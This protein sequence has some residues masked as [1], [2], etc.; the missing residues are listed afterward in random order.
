MPN[1]LGPLRLIT[2]VRQFRAYESRH[3]IPRCGVQLLASVHHRASHCGVLYRRFCS[4]RRDL[5]RTAACAV[6]HWPFRVPW[7]E[8]PVAN[9]GGRITMRIVSPE[10]HQRSA[11][12]RTR[13]SHHCCNPR[14]LWAASLS[15]GSLA[16][17]DGPA[18]PERMAALSPGLAR[19]GFRGR[20]YPGEPPTTVSKP[21]RFASSPFCHR[22]S[23]FEPG[24]DAALS[25]LAA[26]AF[27]APRVGPPPLCPGGPTLG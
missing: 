10:N 23:G 3:T 17:G 2:V 9:F 22:V 6:D 1:V 21:E 15:L 5:L 19:Q 11:L 27:V 25:E 8:A 26:R 24:G 20:A 14:V 4:S 7:L 16:G 12:Q 18:H 13:P